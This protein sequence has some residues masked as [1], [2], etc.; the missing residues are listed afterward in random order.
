MF[1][2][3]PMM[4]NSSKGPSGMIRQLNCNSCLHIMWTDNITGSQSTKN[5][6]IAAG[7]AGR[8]R[9]ECT[10]NGKYAIQQCLFTYEAAR[11]H[12]HDQGLQ[13]EVFAESSH[14]NLPK[15]HPLPDRSNRAQWRWSALSI[16]ELACQVYLNVP[17]A[18]H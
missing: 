12:D 15:C 3:E 1:V 5:C 14:A 10:F 2:N 16:K 6:Q 18:Y 4:S 17:E 7:A 8:V 9:A 11:D 13:V